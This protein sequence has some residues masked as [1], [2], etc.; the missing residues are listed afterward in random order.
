MSQPTCSYAQ[1]PNLWWSH[2]VTGDAASRSQFRP[3]F[4]LENSKK[5]R[6]REFRSFHKIASHLFSWTATMAD[7]CV[8]PERRPESA[9]GKDLTTV[10][11]LG[12]CVEWSSAAAKGAKKSCCGPGRCLA[13]QPSAFG[14]PTRHSPLLGV[15]STWH[16]ASAA[17]GQP[18]E[19]SC[20]PR[21][22]RL[23]H[24]QNGLLIGGGRGR[25]P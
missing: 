12:L 9:R 10:E 24:L 22:W 14:G 3:P 4:S 7:T 18:L 17:V 13:P 16:G 8:T 5:R 11:R 21:C 1:R 6:G 25:L 2:K 19:A 23:C 15:V 20:G